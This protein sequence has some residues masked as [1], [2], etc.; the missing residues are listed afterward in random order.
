MNKTKGLSPKAV[1]AFCFPAIASI[2]GA[3][4]TYI[5]T[6]D[7][8]T[9]AIRVAAGGLVSSGLALLGAYLGAPGE[10]K[11]PSVALQPFTFTTSTGSS[12]WSVQPTMAGTM[13]PSGKDMTTPGEFDHAPEMD[14]PAHPPLLPG[15]TADAIGENAGDPPR[16]P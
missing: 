12:S 2:G 1:L 9:E 7:L 8:D 16:L 3:L 4:G 14:P 5:V 15:E 6:G 13:G 11:L 10:L